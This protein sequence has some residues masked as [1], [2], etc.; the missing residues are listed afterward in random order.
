[1]IYIDFGKLYETICILHAVEL[2]SEHN[3]DERTV[4][5][6]KQCRDL[7]HQPLTLKEI[8][9]TIQPEYGQ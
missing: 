6:I 8:S 7:L 1:M 2:V 4:E 5:K 9:K 3:K